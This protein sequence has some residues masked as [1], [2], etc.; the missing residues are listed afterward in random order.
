MGRDRKRSRGRSRTQH[1]H[2]TS[3]FKYGKYDR[4]TSSS[5]SSSSTSSVNSSVVKYRKSKK[6]G[7][8]IVACH[9]KEEEKIN[10]SLDH[11]LDQETDLYRTIEKNQR[12]IKEKDQDPH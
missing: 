8:E 6:I 3:R 5:I 10:L 11:D 12:K 1:N 2:Q 7:E 4:S 9:L